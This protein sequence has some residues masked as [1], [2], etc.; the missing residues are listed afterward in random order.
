MSELPRPVLDAIRGHF[1]QGRY[2]LDAFLDAKDLVRALLGARVL[3]LTGDHMEVVRDR[4]EWEAA[5][6]EMHEA[7]VHER[8]ETERLRA[9][10]V[11]LGSVDE[12]ARNAARAALGTGEQAD[13]ER[14]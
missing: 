14:S 9:A 7:L 5:E 13:A 4:D 2:S 8:A 11:L 6:L 10:V 1:G 3:V 12:R